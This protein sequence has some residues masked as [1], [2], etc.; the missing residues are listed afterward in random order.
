MVS[1]KNLTPPKQSFCIVAFYTSVNALMTCSLFTFVTRISF[2][3]AWFDFPLQSVAIVPPYFIVFWTDALIRRDNKKNYPCVWICVS[4]RMYQVGCA[5]RRKT[6]I[7]FYFKWTLLFDVLFLLDSDNFFS[8]ENSNSWMKHYL[9]RLLGHIVRFVSYKKPIAQE[10]IFEINEF[11]NKNCI[12]NKRKIVLQKYIIIV[13]VY[14]S[15][16]RGI[17]ADNKIHWLNSIESTN[18]N[19]LWHTHKV[20]HHK[21]NHK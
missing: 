4:E 19:A 18:Q 17:E 3:L 10:V 13:M 6:F 21:N 8:Q 16:E 15:L 14:K 9:Q 5:S 20:N 7:L 2:P 11:Y 12:Y 1:T